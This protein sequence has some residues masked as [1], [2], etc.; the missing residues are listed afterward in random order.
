MT[1]VETFT[2]LEVVEEI[3][4]EPLT[5]P[6][7]QGLEQLRAKLEGEIADFEQYMID[8]ADAEGIAL[9]TT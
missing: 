1:T 5:A 4:N 7:R 6:A 8:S 3:L 2:M 9:C